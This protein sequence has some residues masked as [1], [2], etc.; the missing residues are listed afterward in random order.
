LEATL[1]RLK[2][3]EEARLNSEE[4]AIMKV[5]EEARIIAEAQA[6]AEEAL[7]TLEA[8][9]EARL[10]ADEEAKAEEDARLKP[11]DQATTAVEK[12]EAIE[13]EYTVA[14]QEDQQH[15]DEIQKAIYASVA[16]DI[17][18]AT[19]REKN[20]SIS[21]AGVNDENDEAVVHLISAAM[22]SSETQTETEA[23]EIEHVT[24][25]LDDNAVDHGAPVVETEIAMSK[26]IAKTSED[27]SDSKVSR[28]ND[29]STGSESRKQEN[30]SAIHTMHSCETFGIDNSK[31]SANKVVANKTN[32]APATEPEAVVPNDARNMTGDGTGRTPITMVTMSGGYVGS[33]GSNPAN[34]NVAPQRNITEKKSEQNNTREAGISSSQESYADTNSTSLDTLDRIVIGVQ[35]D[36]SNAASSQSGEKRDESAV[37]TS[38]AN[39]NTTQVTALNREQVPGSLEGTQSDKTSSTVPLPAIVTTRNGDGRQASQAASV[40]SSLNTSPSYYEKFDS[41]IGS[42]MVLKALHVPVSE[43]KTSKDLLSLS[44][45]DQSSKPEAASQT[46]KSSF[47]D[48]IVTLTAR[49]EEFAKQLKSLVV[50]ANEFHQAI[51]EKEKARAKFFEEC[52]SMTNGTPLH[53]DIGKN[54]IPKSANLS[55]AKTEVGDLITPRSMSSVEALARIYS[56]ESSSEYQQHILA[57]VTA[58]T[59]AVTS[60]VEAELQT[61]DKL[62]ETLYHYEV[63]VDELRK[64]SKGI[65]STKLTRNYK[66]LAISGQKRDAQLEKACYLLK[67]VVENSWK[68][69]YPL[70]E[71]TMVWETNRRDG[72]VD[73]MGMMLPKTMANMKENIKSGKT[74]SAPDQ[75]SLEA[76]LSTQT[77]ENRKLQ[78]RINK[79]EAI[80]RSDDWSNK[81][82]MISK[83]SSFKM[84]PTGRKTAE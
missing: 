17:K 60:K 76:E 51:G 26:A 9:E 78:Y 32:G 55:Y 19:I 40:C 49:Y 52:T 58:W 38:K 6:K 10:K 13:V 33:G 16:N 30:D 2:A 63:K 41:K 81:N 25:R 18:S 39:K 61:Y 27:D 53:L 35:N 43:A 59:E 1:I 75:E 47:K 64:K 7:A 3:K 84:R 79:L 57:Y 8:E 83:L 24:K 66:K 72:Q 74:L 28:T 54:E 36:S 5:E 20:E 50:H 70:I 15:A 68:D 73:T 65:T 23:S 44:D 22:E 48:D 31:A 12:S 11:L 80:L 4:E 34:S 42:K 67:A 29:A 21:D 71:Q 56:S 45:D 37:N 14:R 82:E 69:L 62:E 46:S 77:R